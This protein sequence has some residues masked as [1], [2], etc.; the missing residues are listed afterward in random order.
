MDDTLPHLAPGT[1]MRDHG[2]LSRRE[3]P[4][5]ATRWNC[6]LL[7]VAVTVVSAACSNSGHHSSAS[8]STIFPSSGTIPH[9]SVPLPPAASSAQPPSGKVLATRSTVVQVNGGSTY[10]LTLKRLTGSAPCLTPGL[11]GQSSAFSVSVSNNGSTPE[12]LARVAVAVDDPSQSSGSRE[13]AAL[14]YSGFCLDFTEP[15][16][17]LQPGQKVT[18]T[19]TASGVTSKSVLV[20]NVISTPDNNVLGTVRLNIGG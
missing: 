8:S 5:S 1:E 12:A 18:Y 20:A 19:G 2:N 15:G 6:L 7:A 17:T 11:G 10:G 4:R 13:V 3:R 14:S 16:G 9:N